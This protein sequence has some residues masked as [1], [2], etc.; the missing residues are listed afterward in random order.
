MMSLLTLVVVAACTAA[1]S[2]LRGQVAGDRARDADSVRAAIDSASAREDW[3]ALNDA[4]S[5]AERLL[6]RDSG[7]ALLQHYRGYAL[8]R[9]ALIAS[10]RED[11][12]PVRG[13]LADADRALEASASSLSLAETHALRASVIGQLIGLNRN[14]LVAM[15]LGPRSGAEMKRAL[16]AGPENPRVWL[17]RGINSMHTP[18]LWGGGLAQAEEFLLKARALF[19]SDTAHSPLPAWG[20]AD[21]EIALGQVHLLQHR[22]SVARDDFARALLLQPRNAWLRDTLM[23]AAARQ[24]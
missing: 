6:T 15:R 3:A 10:R 21:V 7:N 16:D 9:L 12:S 11:R 4:A 17:I 1:V 8:F 20:K 23:Q 18:R 22:D 13:L 14:P 5:L 24:R 19:A 2:P